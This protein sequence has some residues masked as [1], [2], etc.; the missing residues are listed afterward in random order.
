MGWY[1]RQQP[2]LMS[3]E[4]LEKVWHRARAAKRYD[5]Y[6]SHTWHTPGYLK[7][8]SLLLAF[9]WWMAL[10]GCLFGAMSAL[11]LYVADILPLPVLYNAPWEEFDKTCPMG[12]YATILTSIF[13]FSALLLSPYLAWGSKDDIFYD[14]ACIHQTDDELRKRGIYGIGG[15]LAVTQELRI[16]WSPLYLTR[17]WCVFELAAY[18]TANPAGRIAFHP[19]F[20]ENMALRTF[21]AGVFFAAISIVS[22]PFPSLRVVPFLQILGSLVPMAHFTRRY[23]REKQMVGKQ[24]EEFDLAKVESANDFDRDFVHGAIRNWYGSEDQF[25]TFVRGRLREEL[26]QNFSATQAPWVYHILALSPC[27][28]SYLDITWALWKGGAPPSCLTAYILA[29]TLPSCIWAVLLL[30]MFYSLCARFAAKWQS[31]CAEWA[32]NASISFVIGLM[33]QFQ[34]IVG[35]LTYGA[36]ALP[37]TSSGNA[38]AE[39]WACGSEIWTSA[40]VLVAVLALTLLVFGI[41]HRRHLAWKLQPLPPP[42]HCEKAAF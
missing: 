26:M 9:H 36:S 4:Q 6:L 28:A 42:H 11:L 41:F 5:M 30:E 21:G 29:M 24:L 14:F 19:L 1:W 23:M 13:G 25:T 38:T 27:M 17:L 8:W 12:P 16:L 2:G 15:W 32:M 10:L 33:F 22:L 39:A 35:R 34:I 40:A 37:T 31:K 3:E 7:F 18:R 20:V